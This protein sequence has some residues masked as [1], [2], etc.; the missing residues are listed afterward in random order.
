MVSEDLRP[1]ATDFLDAAS[2]DHPNMKMVYEEIDDSWR[3]GSYVTQYF[4]D[5]IH[6]TYWQVVYQRS[7]DGEYNGLSDKDFFLT[8][9]E[10]YETTVTRYRKIK[11]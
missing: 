7:T 5:E 3:H 8:E 2:F 10:P 11:D 4:Y 1:S 6:K 9:V